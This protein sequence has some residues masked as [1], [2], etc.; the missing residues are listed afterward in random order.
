MNTAIHFSSHDQ[1]WKT[2]V[3][4]YEALNKE[5]NFDCDPCPPDPTKDAMFGNLFPEL[6]M[7]WGER[8]FVNPPY[9]ECGEWIKKAYE[10]SLG[11][12]LSVLLIPS[13]TDVAWFHDYI[14]GKAEIRFV[15]GR[16]KFNDGPGSA[17]F[18]SMIVI[19]K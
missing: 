8:N 10:L 4:V 12:V 3:K 13:R 1:T 18:P 6:K 2:P 5:F 17:P 9:N 11:G 16:L 14:L 19:F 7:E 15:R